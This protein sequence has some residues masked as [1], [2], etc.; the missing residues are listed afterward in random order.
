MGNPSLINSLCGVAEAP[1]WWLLYPWRS[2]NF[3]KTPQSKGTFVPLPWCN[4]VP[5]CWFSSDLHQLYSW[6]KSTWTKVGGSKLGRSLDLVD[7]AAAKPFL[8][9]VPICPH[10][11]HCLVLP[12]P[13]SIPPNL[14]PSLLP[15]M[16]TRTSGHPESTDSLS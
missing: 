14:P 1:V 3:C 11:L 15:P 5:G 10:P 4:P 9:M 8:F 6:H 12:I 16:L 7:T 2:F 13:W